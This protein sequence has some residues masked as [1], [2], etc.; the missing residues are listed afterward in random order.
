VDH[1]SADCQDKEFFMQYLFLI[2]LVVTSALPAQTVAPTLDGAYVLAEE[3]S[4]PNGPINTLATLRFAENGSVTGSLLLHTD[5]DL[6]RFDVQGSYKMETGTVGCMTLSTSTTDEDGNSITKDYK[7]RL[8]KNASQELTAVRSNAGYLAKAKIYP[9]ARAG[10]S[11]SYVF[12]DV[13]TNQKYSRL[14]LFNLDTAGNVTGFQYIESF[15]VEEMRDIKGTF[16]TDENGFGKLMLTA[17]Q[18]N[19]DGDMQPVTETFFF[20]ATPTEIKLIRHEGQVQL[21]TLSR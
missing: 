14:G 9:A 17:D 18:P 11:G 3:G 20:L 12:T 4:S 15:G 19:A 16:L 6:L 8:L 10:L 21:L 5:F 2:L 13:G 7:Y 1:V